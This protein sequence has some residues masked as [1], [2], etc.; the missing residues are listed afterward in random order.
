MFI[1]GGN[2]KQELKKIG[3]KAEQVATDYIGA[4]YKHA[5]TRIEAKYPAAYLKRCHRQYVVTVPAVWS[6]KA[7]DATLKA[8]RKIMTEEAAA[9]SNI[10]GES[11]R[12]TSRLADHRTR[13]SRTIHA[14]PD[15]GPIP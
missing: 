2:G 14:T 8:S 9:D 7:K 1:P 12:D 13:S 10:G 15:V 5:I 6:D 4:L 11:G 3:K